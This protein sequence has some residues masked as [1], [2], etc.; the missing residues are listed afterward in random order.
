MG[1][2]RTGPTLRTLWG[3]AKSPEMRMTDEELHDFVSANTG[4]DSLKALTKEEIGL[5]VDRL[6]R[7]KNSAAGRLPRRC[8]SR[9]NTNTQRQR[10]KIYKL[11]QA[12]GW[13]S[14]KR[15]NGFC[16]KMFGVASV[17]WLD[18]RQCSEMIEAMKAMAARQERKGK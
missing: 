10:A 11:A 5:L 16:R 8:N 14:A 15:V 17:E 7:M 9:G 6:G 1:K 13:D 3:I 4:K 18:Y 2:T 12:L